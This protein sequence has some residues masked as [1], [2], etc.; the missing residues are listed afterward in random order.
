MRFKLFDIKNKKEINEKLKEEGFRKNKFDCYILNKKIENTSMT[1]IFICAFEPL[2]AVYNDN[3][4]FSDDL[5]GNTILIECYNCPN[6]QDVP[7]KC[8]NPNN[9]K[10]FKKFVDEANTIFVERYEEIKA[11]N[12]Q[13]LDLDFDLD[14]E[15]LGV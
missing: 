4:M 8:S 7:M 2:N 11:L 1:I 9:C 6:Y 15:D 5:I 10:L 13:K 14:L 3:D 12:E